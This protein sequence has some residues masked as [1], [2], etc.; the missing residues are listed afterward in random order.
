MKCHVCGKIGPDKYCREAQA[1]DWFHGYLKETVHFCP[2]HRKSPERD[3]LFLLSQI[4]AG[5]TA[6]REKP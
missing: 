5:D 4:K 3:R 2:D 6:L 1:W